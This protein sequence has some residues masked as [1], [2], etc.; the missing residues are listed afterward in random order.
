MLCHCMLHLSCSIVA[1][2]H[3]AY[4]H[5]HMCYILDRGFNPPPI[6]VGN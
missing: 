3:V 4:N 2:R 5:I 1:H 6:K